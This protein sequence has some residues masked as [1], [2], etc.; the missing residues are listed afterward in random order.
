M[1]QYDYANWS[2]RGFELQT[3]KHPDNNHVNETNQAVMRLNYK[4]LIKIIKTNNE[5]MKSLDASSIEYI[6]FLKLHQK[7]LEEKKKMAIL[8]N[9]VVQ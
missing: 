7:L 3:Q 4:K 6:T 2:E 9:I 5:K 1:I 8:L